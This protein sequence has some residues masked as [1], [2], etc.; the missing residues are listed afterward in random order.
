MLYLHTL[1][2]YPAKL[3]EIKDYIGIFLIFEKEILNNKTKRAT[4]FGR[5]KAKHIQ[6]TG[7]RR[8]H[9]G[10]GQRCLHHLPAAERR[11]T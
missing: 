8:F 3:Q 1:M 9:T 2:A 5:N 10:C 7:F 11:D 4:A 6:L